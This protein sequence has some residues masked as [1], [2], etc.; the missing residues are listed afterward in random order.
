MLGSS[1][2]AHKGQVIRRYISPNAFTPTINSIVFKSE[3]MCHMTQGIPSFDSEERIQLL[4]S[5]RGC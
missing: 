2:T 5:G 4:H 3:S 1:R